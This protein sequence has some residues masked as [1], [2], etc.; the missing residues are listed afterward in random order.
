[1]CYVC[2]CK[3][4][5]T[6]P[7]QWHYTGST[8]TTLLSRMSSRLFD[9]WAAWCSSFQLLVLPLISVACS[10]WFC[11]HLFGLLC[12]VLH[13]RIHL[14]VLLRFVDDCFILHG[15]FVSM[16]LSCLLCNVLQTCFAVFQ[17]LYLFCFCY[18]E[19]MLLI[20]RHILLGLLAV[21]CCAVLA[22]LRCLCAQTVTHG[23]QCVWVC[24]YWSFGQNEQINSVSWCLISQC[25][26]TSSAFKHVHFDVIF[27]TNLICS[28]LLSV[29]V[30]ECKWVGGTGV[31]DFCSW[32]CA[33]W[34]LYF[35]YKFVSAR[36]L[37]MSV[38]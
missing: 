15:W 32:A 5:P 14:F 33:F 21:L 22:V 34:C 7:L 38:Q 31:L 1:M 37:L 10:A 35:S 23:L 26:F 28:F 9:T 25:T 24:G 29:C 4:L 11:A 8:F 19:A 12:F 18:C 36:F 27:H 30:C 17:W 2:T 6:K 20:R 16:F 3:L 13:I